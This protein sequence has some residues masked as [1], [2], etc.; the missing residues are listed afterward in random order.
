MGSLKFYF[1]MVSIICLNLGLKKEKSFSFKSVSPYQKKKKK[2]ARGLKMA[3]M[4]GCCPGL[5]ASTAGFPTPSCW[6]FSR[7]RAKCRSR[8]IWTKSWKCCKT[9]SADAGASRGQANGASSLGR[10]CE[11]AAATQKRGGRFLRR[12]RQWSAMYGLRRSAGATR[13]PPC[14]IRRQR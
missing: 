11:T 2:R 3:F 10:R 12:F 7:R 8:G 1:L 14:R 13:M 6:M 4:G 9:R 5:P